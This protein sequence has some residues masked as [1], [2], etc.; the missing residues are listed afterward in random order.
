[1]SLSDFLKLPEVTAKLKQEVEKPRFSA[2]KPLL[3]PVI[4]S[5]RQKMGIA[6]DYALRF[7]ANNLNPCAISYRWTAEKSLEILDELKDNDA[8]IIGKNFRLGKVRNI[9]KISA[10]FIEDCRSLK[11]QYHSEAKNTVKIEK[12]NLDRYLKTRKMDDKLIASAINLAELD[13]LAR[14]GYLP[15]LE[16]SK[17]D[18]NDMD[19]LRRII[20][21]INPK[22]IKAEHTCVL[23]PCFG[24]EASKLMRADGDLVLDNALI[25][26]KTVEG[27]KL[28]RKIFNQLLG[29]YTLYR[30]G[31]IKGMPPKNQITKIGIY[32]SRHAYLHTY[33]I[34]DI[35]D[36]TTYAEFIE[37]FKEK[38]LDYFL[39]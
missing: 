16:R 34:E 33:D 39:S 25:D 11:Y 27:L 14:K 38:A 35:I 3:A 8:I 17:P 20:S 7:Y 32:F 15:P 36:E 37:W 12:K 26:I 5:N 29:Y 28:D 30:I 9:D 24:S 23:N 31:G 4:T 18:K 1:L 19:D 21:I 2:N 10:R 22:T 13:P 6:A